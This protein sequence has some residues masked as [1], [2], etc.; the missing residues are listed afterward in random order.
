MGLGRFNDRHGQAWTDQKLCSRIQAF[1]RLFRTQDRAGSSE[2]FVS[3]LADDFSNHRRRIRNSHGD[4]DHWDSSRADGI[5][6]LTRFLEAGG[7]H[8]G[9]DSN[10]SDFFQDFIDVHLF[11]VRCTASEKL[12]SI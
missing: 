7:S 5:D 4:F 8:H 12:E 10:F 9:N 1:R 3:V 11:F 2:H 6:R